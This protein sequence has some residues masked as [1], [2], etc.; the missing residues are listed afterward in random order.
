MPAVACV[1]LTAG[2]ART[3]TEDDC[4]EIGSAVKAAWEAEVKQ[5][6]PAAGEPAATNATVVLDSEGKK[7]ASEWTADCRRQLMGRPV[8][9]K[10]LSCLTRSKTLEELGQCAEP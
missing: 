1:L 4:R 2:C 8:D 3:V 10:E 6:A 9:S 5:A 7:L